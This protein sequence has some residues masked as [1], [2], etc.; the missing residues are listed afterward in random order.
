MPSPDRRGLGAAVL[1]LATALSGCSLL[2]NAP[3]AVTSVLDQVPAKTQ[4][5]VTD[6]RVSGAA[7]AY[8]FEVEVSSPDTGCQR[9]ADWWEVL[10]EE[11]GLLYRRVLLHSHVNE[12]PFRR[13]GGPV[14]VAADRVVWVR[15]HM[16][17]DGY[18]GTAW[19]GTAATGLAPTPLDANF[20]AEVE[21]QMPQPTDCAF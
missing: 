2:E 3:A 1:V 7:G 12:Q 11:G 20:A 9:Y 15:A 21:A 16:H 17:P 4:A 18:G 8:T 6:V 14:A 13:T 5:D 10:D 19:R